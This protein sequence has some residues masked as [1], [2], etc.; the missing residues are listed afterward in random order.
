MTFLQATLEQGEAVLRF[1]YDD[2]LRKLLRAI[3]GRRWDPAERAWIVPLDPERAQAVALLLESLPRPALVSEP[4]S[5]TLTRQRMRRSHDECVLDLARPDES[6]WLT[7]ATDRALGIVEALLGHDE[8]HELPTIGRALIPLDEQAARLVDT[9]PAE[10]GRLRLSEDAAHALTEVSQRP[11]ARPGAMRYD[12]ELK[13]DRRKQHWVLIAADHAALARALAARSDLRSLEGPEGTF[14][15][16]A[17]ER[18][19]HLIVE[20]LEQLE[21]AGIDP[22]VQGWLARATT[23]R[24]TIDVAGEPDEPVFLLLG[25]PIGLPRELRERALSAPGGVTIPLTLES[26]QAIEQNM[27]GFTSAAARR[28]V[29]ALKEGRPAPPAVLE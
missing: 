19:A 17:V 13:R 11:A 3:P 26:W 10:A 4:L 5:R 22:R 25:D 6:W 29:A 2:V 24:G 28:C 7:F 14:A 15:L 9:L 23:W 16:A 1:P 12:V 21:P 8:A 20:L 27:R 18:D